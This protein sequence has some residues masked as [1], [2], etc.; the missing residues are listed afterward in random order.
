MLNAHQ[1]RSRAVLNSFLCKIAGH[2]INRRRVWNDSVD[3]R[4]TCERCGSELLRDESRWRE[5]DPAGDGD[6]RRE[7]HP[8]ERAS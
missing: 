1:F 7:P 2:R 5:F 6:A 8:H 3:F 4:T